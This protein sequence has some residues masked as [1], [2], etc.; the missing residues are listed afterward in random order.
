MIAMLMPCSIKKMNVET[1][2]RCKINEDIAVYKRAVVK[3]KRAHDNHAS[4]TETNDDL[5]NRNKKISPENQSD[6]LLVT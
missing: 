5:V 3:N 6:R 1:R 2:P 4:G